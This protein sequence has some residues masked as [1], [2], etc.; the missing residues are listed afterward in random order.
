MSLGF[1]MPIPSLSEKHL[2]RT[3][4]SDRMIWIQRLPQKVGKGV[5]IR[6]IQIHG[7]L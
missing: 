4:P 5:E 3:W 6:I 7:A 1:Q 2:C